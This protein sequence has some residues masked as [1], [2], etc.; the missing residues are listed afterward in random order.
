MKTMLNVVRYSASI[1]VKHIICT[2]FTL[3]LFL[4]CMCYLL[5]VPVKPVVNEYHLKV[6]I[7]NTAVLSWKYDVKDISV[8]SVVIEQCLS[9]TN[10]LEHN[11]TTN[12][13]QIIELSVSDG[14]I[15]FLV[16]YQDGLE[17]YRSQAFS[18]VSEDDQLPGKFFHLKAF[19]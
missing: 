11:V 3:A 9:N 5:F 1:Q 14:D 6:H 13:D 19:M 2:V 16:I 12:T 18:Q 8:T 7:D 4:Y 10:C 17:A 15:F